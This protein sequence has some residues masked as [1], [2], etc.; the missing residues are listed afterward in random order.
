MNT[1]MIGPFDDDAGISLVPV[2]RNSSKGS[3]LD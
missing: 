2:A 1:K 3:N